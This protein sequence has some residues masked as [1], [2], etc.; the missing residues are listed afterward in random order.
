[1]TDPCF[2]KLSLKQFVLIFIVLAISM[3]GF[4]IYYAQQSVDVREY[5]QA[6][7]IR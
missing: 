2:I 7:R 3:A 5:R 6:L 1:V 4:M